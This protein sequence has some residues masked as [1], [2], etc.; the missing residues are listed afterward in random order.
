MKLITYLFFFFLTGNLF[1]QKKAQLELQIGHNNPV[2]LFDIS[3]SG[4]YMVSTDSYGNIKVWDIKSGRIMNTMSSFGSTVKDLE[5]VPNKSVFAIRHS[6][7]IRVKSITGK[8]YSN[9]KLKN[10]IY[11]SDINSSG[12]LLYSTNK[13]LYIR[14]YKADSVLYKTPLSKIRK[15][16]FIND[17]L[18]IFER[19]NEIFH[20]NWITGKTA[21]LH[22]LTKWNSGNDLREIKT[23]P[24]DQLIYLENDKTIVLFNT[25]GDKLYEFSPIKNEVITTA[26]MVDLEHVYI[27]SIVNDVDVVNR[28][29]NINSGKEIIHQAAPL[30]EQAYFKNWLFKPILHKAYP[31]SVFFKTGKVI[32]RL[33][34]KSNELVQTYESHNGI[35]SIGKLGY[36]EEWNKIYFSQG[37]ISEFSLDEILEKRSWG[38]F[39]FDVVSQGG[40]DYMVSLWYAADAAI[41]IAELSPDSK[42][43]TIRIDGTAEMDDPLT[44][45]FY[46]PDK[47]IFVVGTDTGKLF[48]LQ[49]NEEKRAF[50]LI[51]IQMNLSS[52]E[53]IIDISSS[54]E[55]VLFE[56]T[57]STFHKSLF[58]YTSTDSKIEIAPHFEKALFLEDSEDIL[59]TTRD[60]K[61]CRIRLNTEQVDTVWMYQ[62]SGKTNFWVSSI[63]Q[64]ESKIA[65][66]TNEGRLYTLDA[67]LGILIQKGARVHEDQIRQVLFMNENRILTSGSDG[68]ICVGSTDKKYHKEVTIVPIYQKK[69]LGGVL[70]Q[71][72]RGWLLYTP[73]NY[74][75]TTNVPVESYH[76]VKDR[77]V[78]MFNQFDLKHNRPDIVLERLNGST[79]ISRAYYNAYEKRVEKL[80]LDIDKLNNEAE[81][82][83]LNILKRKEIPTR[84]TKKTWKIWFEAKD[85]LGLQSVNCWV[86]G[87]PVFGAK[88]IPVIEEERYKSSGYVEIELTPGLNKIQTT[89]T[90]IAGYQ[91]LFETV[92]IYYEAEAEKPNLYFFGIG[93]AEYKNEQKNLDYSAKDIRDVL[94]LLNEKKDQFNAIHVDTTFNANAVR[95]CVSS[96]KSTMEKTNPNDIVIV[97]YSGHGLLDSSLNYYLAT[98]DIDFNNPSSKGILYDDIEA[99]FDSIPSR[100][101]VMFLDACHSGEVDEGTIRVSESGEVIDQSASSSVDSFF[102][103]DGRDSFELMKELFTDVRKNSGA[104]VIASSSGKYYSIESDVY[105]NSVFTYALLEGLNKYGDLNRDKH[106]SIMELKEYVQ[107]RVEELTNGEQVPTIRIENSLNDFRLW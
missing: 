87:I 95:N 32:K 44:K 51:P 84:T 77:K 18:I 97:Y 26:Q 75:F 107:F 105:E 65:L 74:Y 66:G 89:A 59:V 71:S 27:M 103:E 10:S 48:I 20:H 5:F 25:G 2:K 78:Y 85:E 90:N 61:V 102:E 99:L 46:F 16:Q 63:D 82:P 39:Q 6:K 21:K 4:R 100:K 42:E 86:N 53:N 79:S 9:I 69:R 93:V 45:F 58:C 28:I 55:K 81:Y 31:N 60:N 54:G 7:T 68:K 12:M 62:Y 37:S 50:D 70:G 17:S 1:G 15:S 43:M 88:G 14:N 41:T 30:K 49:S 73:D 11:S 98:H 38:G 22:E 80:G 76:F 3:T 19:E 64:Y 24:K 35:H 104:H 36:S 94:S 29:I 92:E 13:T 106:L 72:T 47:D 23:F 40:K 8:T 56:R 91:S 83:E 52:N 33:D 101:K 34:F 96:W 67:E 57:D